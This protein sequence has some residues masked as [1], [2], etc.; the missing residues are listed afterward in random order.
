MNTMTIP[1]ICFNC[2]HIG[3]SFKQKR[4]KPIL[5]IMYYQWCCLKNKQ[6]DVN[7][8]IER[9]DWCPLQQH[10]GET[11]KWEELSK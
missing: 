10:A 7:I 8:Y 6:V 2:K 1:D 3:Q 11:V 9:P 4:A 5:G